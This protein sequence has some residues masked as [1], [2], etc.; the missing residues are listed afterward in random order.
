MSKYYALS[1]YLASLDGE[2]WQASFDE[3]EEVLGFPLPP[4]ARQHQAWWSN[5]SRAHSLAWESAGWKTTGVDL[6]EGRVTF[7]YVGGAP[8]EDDLDE[9]FR[10]LTIKEA[11]AGL[12]ET[13]GIDPACIEIVIRA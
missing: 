1:K 13:L 11:K 12:A 7:R 9:G 4:S 10:P 6:D 5:Q 3:V 2:E 8:D